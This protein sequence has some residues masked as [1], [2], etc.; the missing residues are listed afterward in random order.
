ML[1][2]IREREG[3]LHTLGNLTLITV[4]A[5]TAASNAGVRYQRSTGWVRVSLALNLEVIA[6]NIWDQ[7]EISDRATLLGDR[8]V[9]LWPFPG[10]EPDL[11][12]VK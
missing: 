1:T 12:S 5:N 6:N 9:E 7:Q 3:L 10:P 2:S 11:R 4:P 8:A